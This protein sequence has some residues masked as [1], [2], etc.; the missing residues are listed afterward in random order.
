MPAGARIAWGG[1][2]W[3]TLPYLT[4]GEDNNFAF[5]EQKINCVNS[6]ARI[7]QIIWLRAKGDKGFKFDVIA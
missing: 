5:H 2:L 7:I 3:T 4:G 1:T 6:V